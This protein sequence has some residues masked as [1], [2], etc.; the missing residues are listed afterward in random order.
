MERN[1][2]L[3]PTLVCYMYHCIVMKG[4]CSI[5]VGLSVEWIRAEK[6][7]GR[8]RKPSMFLVYLLL[9]IPN[10]LVRSIFRGPVRGWAMPSISMHS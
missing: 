3:T 1:V 8:E 6:A 10:G 7:L 9:N 4:G 2:L 5:R